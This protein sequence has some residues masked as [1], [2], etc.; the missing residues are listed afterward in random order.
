MTVTGGSS[1]LVVPMVMWGRHPPVH[2]IS[3]IYLL[4]DQK[5]LVSGSTD[6]QVFLWE[7]DATSDK[8]EMTPRHVLVGHTAPIKCIAKAS[9]GA[10]AHH[11]V[12]SSENGEMFCWDTEDGR[13]IENKKLPGLIHTH[14]Q[15]YRSPDTQGSGTNSGNTGPSGVKLFCCGFYEEIIAMDPFSLTVIFQLSSRINPDWVASFHVLRPR[16]RQDDVVLGKSYFLFSFFSYFI[17]LL[18]I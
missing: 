9:G 8:W 5:T 2:C 1:S 15:A 6:G 10:D 14:I 3:A 11:I 4:R 7:V 13:C 17:F 18:V 12:T 16:N